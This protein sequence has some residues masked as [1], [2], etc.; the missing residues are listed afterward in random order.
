MVSTRPVQ[1]LGIKE[2]EGSQRQMVRLEERRMQKRLHRESQRHRHGQEILQRSKVRTHFDLTRLC[3]LQ[4][5]QIY[6]ICTEKKIY[7]I[8]LY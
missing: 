3:I 4:I 2:A 8:L 5:S 7:L 6:S 1:V